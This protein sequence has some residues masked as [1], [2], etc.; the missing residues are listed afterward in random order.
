MKIRCS[1]LGRF[2][3]GFDKPREALSEDAKSLLLEMAIREK[4]NREPIIDSKEMQKGRRVEED[5]ITL[6]SDVRGKLYIKNRQYLKN[7]YIHGTLD[8]QTDDAVIDIKSPFNL[9]T[10]AKAE[11][12]ASYA[13]QLTGYMW[14]ANKNKAELAYCLVDAPEDMIYEELK[15]YCYMTN[16]FAQ[17]NEKE[18]GDLE[19]KVR[20]MM[21]Y[22][23]IPK[24]KRV[25][26][27]EIAR[28]EAK[29]EMI[30]A[31]YALALEHYN[32]LLQKI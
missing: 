29:I 25:K 17:N 18:Y 7:E 22:K 24:E 13:W 27:F 21:T 4:Y 20:H 19:D 11:V 1:S 9:F 3:G 14:L 23:D 5:S 12:E 16:T 15:R 6:L 10:F 8:L 26:V 30:K 31:K 2:M 32:F 28:D